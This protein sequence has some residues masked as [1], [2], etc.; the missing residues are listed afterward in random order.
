MDL[1]RFFPYRLA[2]LAEAVSQATAQ[3]YNER[4]SLTRDGWRVLAALHALGEAKTT[5]VIEHTTLDK[6]RVSRA[7]AHLERDGLV[8]RS[9]DPDDGRGYLVRLL[10]PGTA[11]FQRIVPMVQAREAF[12]LGALDETERQ[13][14][15]RALD[16]LQERADQLRRQG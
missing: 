1:H 11:L 5:R 10:P 15:D 3:V 8:Q 2:R 13:V 6:M 14:L 12:L 16:R 7:L 9:T 4:F